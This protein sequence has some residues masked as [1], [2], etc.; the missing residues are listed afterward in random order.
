MS[1][2]ATSKPSAAYDFTIQ[3]SGIRATPGNQ[4]EIKPNSTTLP[5]QH[6]TD[7][8]HEKDRRIPRMRLC[9]Y[10]HLPGHQIY[11]CKAK[12][13]D[14]AAQLIRQ[15]INAGIR[16][17]EDDVHCQNEMI[18]TRTDGGQW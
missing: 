14:E 18:V 7:E 9:Y 6:C 10:C 3:H 17:Q 4:A 13:N 15:A 2:N 16:K 11:N 1:V 5:C 8:K 12:E